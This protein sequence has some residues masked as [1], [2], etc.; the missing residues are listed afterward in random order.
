MA[1]LKSDINVDPHSEALVSV[2]C[3]Y[4]KPGTFIAE[5]VNSL[6]RTY[7]TTS[8][9]CVVTF[10][11]GSSVLRLLNP[12]DI[13]VSI[14]AGTTVAHLASIH[15]KDIVAYLD[16][17]DESNFDKF[18]QQN[19]S[20]SSTESV[21]IAGDLGIDLSN[22][23]LDSSQKVKLLSFLGKYRSAFANDS[24]EL[25]GT[26]IYHH[27]I[28]TGNAPPIRRPPYKASPK[29]AEEIEQQICIM[30]DSG[31]I[32]P[33]TSEW[34]SPVVLVKKKNTTW[35]FAIDY[36]HLN[37]VTDTLMFPIAR[38]DEVV[39]TIAQKKPKIF[40][41]L[42]MASGFLQIPLDQQTKHKTAFVTRN[43]IYQFTRMPFG[44]KNAPMAFSMVMRRF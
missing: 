17:V 42:D 34:A 44:L 15:D 22:S 1:Y 30:E 16:N 31:H 39:D 40:S 41:V 19:Q 43:G 32:E 38:F 25:T 10:Y 29:M 35:R 4:K 33:S 21:Q 26:S 9:R 12:S 36:S 23:T 37:S 20:I 28:H 7:G 6:S 8:A 2:T 18:K 5:P 27:T 11:D 3:K 13:P 24:T 14:Q